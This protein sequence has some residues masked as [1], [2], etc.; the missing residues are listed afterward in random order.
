[1][2]CRT[3]DSRLRSLRLDARPAKVRSILEGAGGP[4]DHQASVWCILALGLSPVLAIP[5][6]GDGRRRAG[7]EI[8][9]DQGARDSRPRPKKARPRLPRRAAKLKAKDRHVQT[10]SLEQQP[11]K[12]KPSSVDRPQRQKNANKGAHKAATRLNPS[13]GR[14]NRGPSLLATSTRSF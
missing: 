9:R 10:Q 2:Q 14:P 8:R 11:K 1:M 4:N 7:P 6:R 5:C 13:A 12:P 3:T